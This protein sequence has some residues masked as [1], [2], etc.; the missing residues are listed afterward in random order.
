MLGFAAQRTLK[1]FLVAVG[2]GER[3]LEGARSRL[4]SIRDFA[5]NSAFQRMD[6]D[7]SGSVSS[8]EFVNFLR[9][10]Q[11]YHVSESEAYQL[12][13]FFDSNGNG[14]LSFQEFLQMFL[15]CEDNFLRNMTLDRPAG[16]VGRYDSLPRD[17][18]QAITSVITA[19]IDLQ[20]RLEGLKGELERNYDYSP[21]AAFNTIDRNRSGRIN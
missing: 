18:E 2:D 12:V 11:V 13:N 8:R 14:K 5:P 3:Q 1:D 7:Y 10:Q 9:D 20:R 6:R 15:P 4:C 17:I 16:R 21:F 19:E